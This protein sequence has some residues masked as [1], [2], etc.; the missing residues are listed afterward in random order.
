ML[1]RLRP[2]INIQDQ[3]DLTLDGWIFNSEEEANS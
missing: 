2:V 1:N 3:S